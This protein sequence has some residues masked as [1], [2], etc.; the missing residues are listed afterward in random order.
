[1][2]DP[3]SNATEQELHE[4][5]TQR[6]RLAQFIDS[7]APGD[8]L[9]FRVGYVNNEPTQVTFTRQSSMGTQR[10]IVPVGALDDAGPLMDAGGNNERLPPPAT[11][12]L[13]NVGGAFIRLVG[14]NVMRQSADIPIS[15]EQL[16]SIPFEPPPQ[17]QAPNPDAQMARAQDS[18]RMIA[19]SSSIGAAVS[20]ENADVANTP[21][22]G[23][24]RSRA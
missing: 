3:Q 4:L 22:T 5:N 12:F 1:M 24:G 11:S 18:V 21:F 20:V 9:S 19:M 15:L 17:M 16:R 8:R 7:S 6:D 23:A 10:I 2:P 14:G 13:G